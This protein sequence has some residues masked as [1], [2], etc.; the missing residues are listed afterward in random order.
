MYP[1]RSWLP[2]TVLLCCLLF[3]LAGTMY[4]SHVAQTQDG[5]R[6]SASVQNITTE[7]QQRIDNA[8]TLLRAGRAL[9]AANEEISQSEFEQYVANMELRSR[10]PGV[11]GI[12]FSQRLRASEVPQLETELRGEGREKFKVWPM[13]PPRE[14]YH[15]IVY[16]EPLDRRNHAALGYDMFSE[17]VRREAMEQ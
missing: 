5:V 7:L 17:E 10:Y 2:W 16:L 12:G 6:F 3:T 15:S 4:V 1:I 9:F 8:L 13:E 14:E 11:Q